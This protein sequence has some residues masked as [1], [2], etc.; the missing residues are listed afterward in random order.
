V[1]IS[2]AVDEL[3]AWTTRNKKNCL[4]RA[5]TRMSQI[6]KLAKIMLLDPSG[7]MENGLLR[8]ALHAALRLIRDQ[9]ALH[10]SL[11]LRALRRKV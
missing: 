10:P 2:G 9:S 7:S 4:E 3:S 5:L 11:S 6:I 8:H 1:G